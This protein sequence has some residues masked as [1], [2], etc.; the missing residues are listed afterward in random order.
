[1]K[2]VNF[3]FYMPLCTLSIFSSSLSLSKDTET[4]SFSNWTSEVFIELLSASN[5]HI[6][7]YTCYIFKSFILFERVAIFSLE[8]SNCETTKILFS[9]LI[10]KKKIFYQKPFTMHKHVYL[11]IYI[12]LY[13]NLIKGMTISQ[14]IK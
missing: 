9:F 6:F 13:K 3:F 7:A 1:M 10:M 8:T 5:I 2:I 4:F 12:I 14:Y 11:E